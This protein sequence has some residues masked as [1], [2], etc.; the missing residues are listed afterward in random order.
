MCLCLCVHVCVWYG[1]M[2]RKRQGSTYGLNSRGW[3]SELPHDMADK[4]KNGRETFTHIQRHR[5]RERENIKPHMFHEDMIHSFIHLCT[6]MGVHACAH[7]H[8]DLVRC[9]WSL[10][11]TMRCSSAGDLQDYK[12]YRQPH[13][14]CNGSHTFCGAIIQMLD[15]GS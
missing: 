12:R 2:V 10:L 11:I 9:V 15:P 13:I 6:S 7:A 3:N 4:N 8:V 5:Q 14:H 1:E